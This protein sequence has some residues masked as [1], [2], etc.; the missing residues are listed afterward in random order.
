[1]DMVILDAD[2]CDPPSGTG[3]EIFFTPGLEPSVFQPGL[4]IQV[5]PVGVK[6]GN[7]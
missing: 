4:R 6:R 3:G 1:V 2:H 5:V 7:L